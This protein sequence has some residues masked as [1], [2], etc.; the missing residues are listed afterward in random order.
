MQ[1]F[2]F[3]IKKSIRHVVVLVG[4][5]I[6]YK[7]KVGLDAKKVGKHCAKVFIKIVLFHAVLL[8]TSAESSIDFYSSSGSSSILCCK[9]PKLD[10]KGYHK[11]IKKKS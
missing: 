4:P 3:R 7:I 8:L 2:I 11:E 1:R 9:N 6:F 5:E 10:S